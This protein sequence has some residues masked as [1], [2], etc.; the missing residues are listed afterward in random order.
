MLGGRDIESQTNGV[1]AAPMDRHVEFATQLSRLVELYAH[2]AKDRTTEKA[3]LRAARAA[4]K[5]GAIELSLAD[6]A[7]RA[8]SVE[9]GDEI[10]NVRMLRGLFGTLGITRFHVAHQARQDDV[11]AIARLLADALAGGPAVEAFA[12]QLSARAWTDVRVERGAEPAVVVTDD[13]TAAQAEVSEG[14]PDLAGVEGAALVDEDVQAVSIDEAEVVAEPTDSAAE[15]GPLATHVP[16]AV[17]ELPDARHRE[18][19]ERLITSSEPVTLRRLLEPIQ[20]AI[21]QSLREGRVS[22][23]LRLL[24]AMFACEG[25]TADPDMR[26]HFVVVVRR[27]TKP[28][29]LRGFAMLYADEPQFSEL[30]ERVMIRFGE[31]GAEAVADRASCAPSGAARALYA[32]LLGKLP[33]ARDA[34]VAML[35]DQRPHVVERAIGLAVALR[36]ADADRVLGEQLNHASVRVR[37]A[38][39]LGLAA[40]PASAFAADALLRAVPDES[41]EVR[42]TA[43]V[44]LQARREPRL[45]PVL[46][47]RLEEEHEL[48]IQLA[49][50]AALGRLAV[51]E[52][53]Q[54]LIALSSPEQRKLRRRDASVLRLS[55]IEA[56]GEA[57][58]PAAMIALQ[59]LLED[60]EEEVREAAGRLFTRARRHTTTGSI[61][62]VS[63]P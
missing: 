13:E 3:V 63:E 28:T 33:G 37:Q 36:F 49:L 31:D 16:S 1:P 53:V 60:R 38:A 57:R 15:A 59:K 7:I 19:F 34:V 25:L 8:G 23:A 35:D 46:V 32:A 6:R 47:Q 41:P 44:A 62:S 14:G 51:P 52:G 2:D 10:P 17:D 40:F 45:A 22:E 12:T 42:L 27:L 30:V 56:L 61:A 21:E 39:A 48:D 58:T 43:T 18:L 55:A 4:A 50:V 29:V 5:H 54:K 20:L 24:L 26:R 9:L 11:K